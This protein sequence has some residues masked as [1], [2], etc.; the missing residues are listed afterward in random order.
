MKNSTG[1][2]KRL[3]GKVLSLALA[4]A[5]V[6]G[7]GVTA[8][9][10]IAER[11]REP[12][13]NAAGQ[14]VL[15]LME[16]YAD[17]PVALAMFREFQR[18][19]FEELVGD[20]PDLVYSTEDYMDFDA[21]QYSES[22]GLSWFNGVANMAV[23]MSTGANA[24]QNLR[25]VILVEMTGNVRTIAITGFAMY[26]PQGVLD[27]PNTLVPHGETTALRVTRIADNAF[28]NEGR[29]TEVVFPQ[30]VERVG[31]RAFAN[32]TT[33]TTIT[34][35]RDSISGSYFG[36]N[37]FAGTPIRTIRAPIGRLEHF[38]SIAA[39]GALVPPPP[40]AH[41]VRF[42]GICL[43]TLN[44]TTVSERCTHI[45]CPFICVR[46]I[47]NVTIGDAVIDTLDAIQIY[48]Y[49]VGESNV[50]G[51]RATNVIHC[52]NALNAAL[53]LPTSR[54]VG[55]RPR[56]AD[57]TDINRFVMGLCSHIGRN[58]CTRPTCNCTS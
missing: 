42:A 30:N 52:Y 17:D 45:N 37:V 29:F 5:M 14:R 20:M 49:V 22:S 39:I 51:V 15:E 4:T 28:A 23:P 11:T 50:I 25:W 24:C 12:E 18:D 57:G 19:T 53:V 34:F 7:M 46:R 9:A 40:N 44:N 41:N 27:I 26:N 10:E 55:G 16:E 8:S 31:N 13:W 33:L 1:K 6:A 2:S 54:V 43:H 47:G 3:L 35:R 58:P 36:A 56:D 32:R 48:R 38:R 21:P